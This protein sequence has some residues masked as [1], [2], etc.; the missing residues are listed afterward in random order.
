M[1]GYGKRAD[2]EIAALKKSEMSYNVMLP[3]SGTPW[4]DRGAVGF[5]PAFI[6]TTFQSLFGFRRLV[7]QIRRPETT[8]DAA[9]YVI[10][11]GV[12][13]AISIGIWDAALYL[14]ATHDPKLMV[15]GQQ[16]LI[17]SVIRSIGAAALTYGIYKLSVALFYSL[18]THDSQRQ[19]PQVIV[20]NVF[21]YAVGPSMLA[22]VPAIAAGATA[23]ALGPD[24]GTSV[25]LAGWSVVTLWIVINAIVAARTRLYLRMRES[26]V[27]VI[28]ATVVGVV[29]VLVIYF[30]CWFAWPKINGEH[31][32]APIP[33]KPKAVM[34]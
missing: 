34:N 19:I 5:I 32:V 6:K 33:E 20:S 4:E 11:C 15:N 3:G 13:W 10:V 12:M 14:Q 30:V 9:V 1:S 18:L 22:L 29:L 17:E 28:I 23:L 8:G 2:I 21:A 16:Y 7:D 31:S 24:T 27:N 26:A 25:L